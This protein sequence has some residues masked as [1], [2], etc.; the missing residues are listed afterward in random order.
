MQRV[1]LRTPGPVLFGTCIYSTCWDQRHPISI[2]HIYQFVTLLPD[3]TFLPNLTFHQ[4]LVSIEHL[5]RVWHADRGCLSS[6]HLVLSHFWTCMCSNVE[7]NLSWTCLVSGLLNFENPSVVRFCLVRL[8][9]ANRECL[10]IWTPYPVFLRQA[11]V[12]IV[13]ISLSQDV[14]CFSNVP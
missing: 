4:I 9:L 6:A 13:K 10:L 12:Q 3:L 1:L 8:W 11:Y 14:L 2:R 5:Q 7:T